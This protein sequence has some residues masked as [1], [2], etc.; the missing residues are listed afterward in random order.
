M[1]R[2]KPPHYVLMEVHPMAMRKYRTDPE[3]FYHSIRNLGYW[4][5]AVDGQ[6]IKQDTWESLIGQQGRLFDT[7]WVR[8][9]PPSEGK[10]E[11][12]IDYFAGYQTDYAYTP[13][14]KAAHEAAVAAGDQVVHI[15]GAAEGVP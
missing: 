6:E 15:A 12:G 11:W 4:L 3:Q 7:L 10:F 8:T 13:E 1:F 14:E 9:E 2:E 5:I